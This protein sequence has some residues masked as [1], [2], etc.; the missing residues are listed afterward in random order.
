MDSTFCFVLF[1]RKLII[2]LMIIKLNL[3]F[4]LSKIIVCSFLLLI[5]PHRIFKSHNE[6]FCAIYMSNLIITILS[7]FLFHNSFLWSLFIS[8]F[9][10]NWKLILYYVSNYEVILTENNGF[11]RFNHSKIFKNYYSLNL[12]FF[13]SQI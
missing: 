4:I 10:I 7:F 13:P 1:W 2:D 12:S 3:K 11:Q 9:P 8:S 5:I 6:Q